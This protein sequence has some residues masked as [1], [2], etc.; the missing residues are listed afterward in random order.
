VTSRI[1][2]D[3]LVVYG[4]GKSALLEATVGTEGSVDGARSWTIERAVSAIAWPGYQ[5]RISA[6]FCYACA[7]VYCLLLEMNQ[8]SSSYPSLVLL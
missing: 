3:L 8:P 2:E 7:G 4:P 5:E 1:L 6:V